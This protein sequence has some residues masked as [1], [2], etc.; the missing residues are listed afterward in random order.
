MAAFGRRV[1]VSIFVYEVGIGRAGGGPSKDCS[2]KSRSGSKPVPISWHRA[3][4]A[5]LSRCR[6]EPNVEADAD[7]T[8]RRLARAPRRKGQYDGAIAHLEAAFELQRQR[9]A[10]LWWGLGLFNM[11]QDPLDQTQ[12]RVTSIQTL[13]HRKNSAIENPTNLYRQVPIGWRGKVTKD[14]KDPDCHAYN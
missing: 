3:T 11:D 10:S 9:A 12:Q 6:T 5:L 2:H 1:P 13:A 8:P 7:W 14:E 4:I